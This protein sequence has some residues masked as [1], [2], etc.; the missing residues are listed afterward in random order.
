MVG[1]G[2]ESRFKA[3]HT[4][5]IDGPEKVRGGDGNTGN[6]SSGRTHPRDVT[7]EALATVQKAGIPKRD[8]EGGPESNLKKY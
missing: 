7:K 2:C 4:A 1:R 6:C 3:E 8:R 5:Y